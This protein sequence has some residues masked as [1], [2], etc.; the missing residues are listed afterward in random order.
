MVNSKKIIKYFRRQLL[1][2]IVSIILVLVFSP[3]GVQRWLN[4]EE[5]IKPSI[6]LGN[7]VNAPKG[8]SWIPGGEFLMGSD[9]SLADPNEKPI[10]PVKVSGFWMDVTHV[11]NNQ[12]SQF[13]KATNYVTTAEKKPDWETLRVQLPP[14]VK[15]PPEHVL[16]AGAMVFTGTSKKVTF[17]NYSEWWAYAPGANWAHPQGSTSS[18]K[19][20]GDHPVV[21]VSYDDALAYANWIGK[22]LPTEAEWEFAARGGLSQNTYS[23]GNKLIDAGKQQANIWDD[24]ITQFPVVNYKVAATAIG[25]TAVGTYPQN[26]Y[27]LSDMS[28]NAWQWV[29]DSYHIDYY[30]KLS[31]GLAGKV[32]INPQG[33]ES[34][35]DPNVPGMPANAPR[36]VMRGGSY[37]CSKSYCLSY[38]T[39]ARRGNDP[40]SPM[41][42]LS[43]RLVK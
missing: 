38:R 30:Q 20:K 23:W 6:H 12:F 31:E 13:V 42:H 9:Q 7:S 27:G 33:P 5:I 16:V 43:F 26:G 25:T 11:T 34:S 17:E 40:F 37:L 35:Y 22:R 32:A 4:S 2:L 21:Q 41:S 10:H 18:I 36:R 28:G 15:K 14:N 8:M 1:F 39:S 19:D 3:Y 29:A 24:D